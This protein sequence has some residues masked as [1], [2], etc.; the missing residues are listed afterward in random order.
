M[1][2]L[3]LYN[4]KNREFKLLGY[5]ELLVSLSYLTVPLHPYAKLSLQKQRICAEVIHRDRKIFFQDF[6]LNLC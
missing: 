6:T 3:V 2:S 5:N 1:K 4:I